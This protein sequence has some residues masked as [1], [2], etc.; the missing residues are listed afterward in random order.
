MSLDVSYSYCINLTE[1]EKF[2]IDKQVRKN[3]FELKFAIFFPFLP[4]PMI[5]HPPTNATQPVV[6]ERVIETPKGGFQADPSNERVVVLSRIKEDSGLVRAAKEACQDREVQDGINHLI[7]E[8]AK[9][10]P[11]PGIGNVPIGNGL[12]EYR[13][14]R[15]GRVVARRQGNFI[16]I[17]GKSGKDK[18]NQKFVINRVKR[19][20]KQG[21]YD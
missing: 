6:I 3:R 1:E 5:P 14:K 16:E 2:K 13:H 12:T 8:L 18:T 15:G 17:L 7:D 11:N 21:L 4:F 9:G 19:N 20:L 10:N